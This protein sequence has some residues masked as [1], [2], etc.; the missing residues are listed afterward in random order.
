MVVRCP[1]CARTVPEETDYC[2]RCGSSLVVPLR[3]AWVARLFWACPTCRSEIPL[4]SQQP[5]FGESTLGCRVCGTAWR[6]DGDA[7]TLTPL[8]RSRRPDGPA[9]SIDDL[10]A[11]LP[12]PFTG[13]TLPARGLM[14]LPGERCLLKVERARM[15][16]PRQSVLHAQAIGRVEILP[17]VYERVAHDPLGPSPSRL[18]TVSHGPFFATN[19]RVVFMGNRKHVETPL[20]RLAAVEV[21]EGYLLLHRAARTD[22]FGFAGESAVRIRAAIQSIQADALAASEALE[23]ATPAAPAPTPPAA[24]DLADAAAPV[25]DIAPVEYDDPDESLDQPRAG[26]PADS[27][28]RD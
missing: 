17:G 18:S 4:V 14:L 15:L 20:V 25:G 12:P 1:S 6:L 3:L 11:S 27:V 22:T 5:L 13:R 2:P 10:L 7:R 16:A 9:E 8:D 21:D 26:V 23:A 19:R 28:A 24:P